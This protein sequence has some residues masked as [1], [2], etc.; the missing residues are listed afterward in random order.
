MYDII[1]EWH[2]FQSGAY[3]CVTLEN[4]RRVDPALEVELVL[5]EAEL[6]RQPQLA[7]I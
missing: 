2:A 5:M 6:Q 1:E 4:F 7:L 3:L